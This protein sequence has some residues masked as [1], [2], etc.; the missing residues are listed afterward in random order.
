[1]NATLPS[2]IVLCLD[3]NTL[4]PLQFLIV[5][6][7]HP[8]VLSLLCGN[9]TLNMDTCRALVIFTEG[10]GDCVLR[11]NQRRGWGLCI[12]FIF[13]FIGYD[14]FYCPGRYCS[15]MYMQQVIALNS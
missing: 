11:I 4:T 14:K 8:I 6:Q 9:A 13:I 10:Q 2:G 3:C 1:M 7:K 15:L 5:T 12:L